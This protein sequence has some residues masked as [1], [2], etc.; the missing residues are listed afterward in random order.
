MNIVEEYSKRKE[1]TLYY[2][3][4][5]TERISEKGNMIYNEYIYESEEEAIKSGLEYNVATWSDINML[6]DGGNYFPGVT[7][8]TPQGKF[9][10]TE[11]Y[12]E[13]Y[14]TGEKEMINCLYRYK[15]AP[16][17]FSEAVENRLFEDYGSELFLITEDVGIFRAEIMKVN[18][19]MIYIESR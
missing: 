1:I 19:E 10:W 15:G 5:P 14:Y 9:I 17:S 12:G 11:I 18:G 16:E 3:A 7:I 4:E 8:C 2:T 13:D 6:A